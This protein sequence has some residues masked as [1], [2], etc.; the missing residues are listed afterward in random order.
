MEIGAPFY[1]AG[2]QNLPG[3]VPSL[4]SED[5]NAAPFDWKLRTIGA[6]FRRALADRRDS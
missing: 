1:A 6:V 2:P 5:A 4:T 3:M